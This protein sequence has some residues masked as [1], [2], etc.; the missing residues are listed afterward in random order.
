MKLFLDF[1]V[2][3]IVEIFNN[4]IWSMTQH[5]MSQANTHSTPG[6]SSKKTGFFSSLSST[7]TN[8]GIGHEFAAED[9]KIQIYYSGTITV[10][11]IKYEDIQLNGTYE[12]DK[13]KQH[14]RDVCKFEAED[15]F[16]MKWVDEEGD[17]C[18]IGSQ[19]EL[20]EAIRL[21]YLN[22]ENELV[23]HVFA[24]VPQKA[25]MQCVGEDRSIYR[26]GARRWRKVYLVNGHKY[27]A[28]RFAKSALCRVCGERI[29][30]LGRQ[31]YKC[32]EC[33][34][35]VHK[36]CHRFIMTN[37]TQTQQIQKMESEA[38][39]TYSPSLTKIYQEKDSGNDSK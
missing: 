34:I 2:F 25:G 9:T 8:R 10:I 16:T 24:N 23:V 12:L 5:Q 1:L 13:F 28:K 6:G 7:S 19:M 39:M 18:T 35:M 22:K 15:E 4:V 17:P 27:Q 3:L 11:Y 26:R 20:D 29:W 14:I 33:K 38:K 21:Y 31:G 30:G 32:L 37:C 36:R